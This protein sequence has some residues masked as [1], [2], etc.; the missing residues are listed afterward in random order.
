M[1]RLDRLTY[2]YQSLCEKQLDV[3]SIQ[4]L[5]EKKGL[6][7]SIRQIQ[8][9]IHAVESYLLKDDQELLASPS[10]KA[11]QAYKIVSKKHKEQFL[12]KSHIDWFFLGR[13]VQPQI[14]ALNNSDDIK[15]LEKE[16]KKLLKSEPDS[17]PD[18]VVSS[19]FYEGVPND[20]FKKNLENILFAIANSK[21][22]KV[23]EVFADY[24]SVG[25]IEKI[26]NFIPSS[27]VFHRGN[28]HVA[29]LNVK[30]KKQQVMVFEIGQLRKVQ[31]LEQ[32]FNAKKC[33]ELVQADLKNRFGITQNIDSKSYS[34]TLEFTPLLGDFI[35]NQY[36]HHSQSFK[37]TKNALQM[38]LTCGINRELV[39]WLFQW[40]SNVRI[41]EPPELI[42]LYNTQLEMMNANTKFKRRFVYSNIFLDRTKG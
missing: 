3:N 35:K 13:A 7:I 27:I 21:H 9:D 19:H 32:A 22:I 37:E 39:G 18:K 29:G 2:I 10:P 28:L 23:G 8:R 20:T 11:K 4:L 41:V 26:N 42:H 14:I 6:E 40:M 16:F 38:S 1:N 30:G 36:W 33:D 15:Y 12:S 24:T 5:L 31:V 25:P 34:I 17:I